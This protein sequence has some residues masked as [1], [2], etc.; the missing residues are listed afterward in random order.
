MP[1]H[2]LTEKESSVLNTIATSEFNQ[3][4]GSIPRTTEESNTWLWVDELAEDNGL[5]MNQVKGVLSSL[6]KKEM[7]GID[8]SDPD[9]EEDTLVCILK[10]GLDVLW[11]NG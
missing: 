4:N 10:N 1:Y 9:P 3:L 6:V 5:T 8:N 7:I 11:T 2:G